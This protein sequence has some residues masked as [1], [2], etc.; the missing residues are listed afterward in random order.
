[1]QSHINVGSGEDVSIKELSNI[2]SDITG[3]VGE[4]LFDASKPDGAPRKLMNND[5]LTTLGWHSKTDMSEGV[6]NAY[7]SYKASL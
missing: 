6:K 7:N 4:I 2:I 5:L 3:Y 1:M